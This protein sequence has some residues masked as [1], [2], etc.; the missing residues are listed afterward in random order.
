MEACELAR[1]YHLPECEE[2]IFKQLRDEMQTNTSCISTVLDKANSLAMPEL[3]I[4]ALEKCSSILVTPSAF[5]DFS[6]TALELCL[7][8]AHLKVLQSR[9]CYWHAVCT[10]VAMLNFAASPPPVT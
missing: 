3:E 8:A 4:L 5:L 1:K 7:S 9:C 2:S 10:S 6:P